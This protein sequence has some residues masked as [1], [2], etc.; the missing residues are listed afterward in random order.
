VPTDLSHEEIMRYS[1]PLLIHEVGL[2]GQKKLKASSALIIGTGRLG[3]QVALY[4]PVRL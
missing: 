4:C 3:S 2:E 1:R